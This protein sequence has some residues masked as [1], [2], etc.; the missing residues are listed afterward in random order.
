MIKKDTKPPIELTHACSSVSSRKGISI[1]ISHMIVKNDIYGI[2]LRF[3]S[4][5]IF[6]GMPNDFLPKKPE[7]LHCD[8]FC[9]KLIIDHKYKVN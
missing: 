1:S 8:A 7:N 5:N 6:T 4:F 9:P 2:Y 3:L